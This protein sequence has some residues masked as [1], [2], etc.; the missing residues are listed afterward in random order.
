MQLLGWAAGTV[1]AMA[2]KYGHVGPKALQDAVKAL[3]RVPRP[4]PKA[5]KSRTASASMSVNS[6]RFSGGST[7]ILT[8]PTAHPKEAITVSC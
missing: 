6:T 2:H 3:D 8:T 7:T 4:K 5:R 1:A